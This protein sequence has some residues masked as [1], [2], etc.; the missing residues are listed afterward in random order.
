MDWKR[1]GIGAA[2]GGQSEVFN[3]FGG[4]GLFG[5]GGSP[6]IDISSELARIN[7]LYDTARTNGQA[8]ITQDFQAQRGELAQSQAARGIYRSGVSQLGLARLGAA[9]QQAISQFNAQLAAAQAGQQSSL[10]NALL[11]RKTALD[12]ADADRRMQSRNQLIGLGGGLL[13]AYLGGPMGGAMGQKV[14]QGG[15]NFSGSNYVSP[16]AQGAGAQSFYQSEFGG[17]P[18]AMP[19]AQPYNPMPSYYGTG[20]NFRPRYG[21]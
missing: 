20:S 19:Q 10:L 15:F 21:Y 14:A 12:A 7:A 8:A 1:I 18:Q 17:L 3:A 11:G 13:G 6:N 16:A 4:G 2:T 5:G 9:R